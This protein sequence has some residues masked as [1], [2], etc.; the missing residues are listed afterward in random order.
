[1]AKV[2]R[3]D[4]F[5]SNGLGVIGVEELQKQGGDKTTIPVASIISPK[6][7]DRK[8]YDKSRIEDLA[9]NIMATGGELL[10]PI[11]VRDEGGGKYLR[12]AGFRRVEAYK[13]LKKESIPALVLPKEKFD[14]EACMLIMMSEN[15][16]REDVNFYDQTVAILEYISLVKGK[17]IEEVKSLLYRVRND[18]SGVTKESDEATIFSQEV[19][20]LTQ[21]LGN[22]TVGSLIN[23]LAIFK[24]SD[25]I[26]DA[27]KSGCLNQASAGL[28]NKLHKKLNEEAKTILKKYC[29]KEVNIDEVKALTKNEEN[30]PYRIRVDARGT[31]ISV[32]RKI[33]EDVIKKIED[34]LSKL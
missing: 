31:H 21:K 5:A 9:N 13:V 28:F 26:I 14:T 20:I 12:I 6:W 16:Q 3:V 4:P 30:A 25:Y 22:I 32:P 1:M 10:Q 24:Y 34:I 11:I 15:L 27:I 23:R 2:E 8:I 29:N 33:P 19:G 17:T 7:H 18:R